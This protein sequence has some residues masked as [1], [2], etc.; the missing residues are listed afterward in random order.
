MYKR[1]AD[2]DTWVNVSEKRAR[3][4]IV[5]AAR[6]LEINFFNIDRIIKNLRDGAVP[7]LELEGTVYRWSSPG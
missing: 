2:S 5:S 7:E 4:E 1:P 3:E 6:K